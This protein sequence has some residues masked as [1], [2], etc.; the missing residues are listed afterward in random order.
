MNRIGKELVQE[1]KEALLGERKP[2]VETDEQ[3]TES[4]LLAALV[5]A[6]LGSETQ[7]MDD[8]DVLARVLTL[9]HCRS[10]TLTTLIG[11]DPNFLR[12]GAR[13][14]VIRD[15]LGTLRARTATRGPSSLT[16]G[17]SRRRN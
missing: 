1:R 2:Q 11:R 4:D 3:K 15:N 14:N 9:P 5:R 16:R 13:N 17:T 6:N 8:T 7:R 10:R 12:R